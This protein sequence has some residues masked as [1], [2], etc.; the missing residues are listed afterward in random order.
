MD[1]LKFNSFFSN[2]IF[3]MKLLFLILFSFSNATNGLDGLR[4]GITVKRR[5]RPN[6]ESRGGY[7][8]LMKPYVLNFVN[9]KAMAKLKKTACF[10]NLHYIMTNHDFHYMARLPVFR[11]LFKQRVPAFITFWK[12]LKL[13]P[14]ATKGK[15]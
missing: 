14:S 7:N 9:S 2:E 13:G 11:A 8:I 1:C 5:S 4:D 6:F 12:N 10:K 15:V 3:K